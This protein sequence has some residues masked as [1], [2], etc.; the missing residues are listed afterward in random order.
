VQQIL[1]YFSAQRDD[2]VLV[3]RDSGLELDDDNNVFT[4]E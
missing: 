4:G 2:R 3:L 1:K